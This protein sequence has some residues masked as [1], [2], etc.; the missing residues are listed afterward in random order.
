MRTTVRLDDNLLT[1]AK[2]LAVDT[3]RTLTQVI[4]DSLRMS[5]ATRQAIEKAEPIMLHTFQGGN[6][7]QPGVDLSNNAALQDLMDEHDGH[8]GR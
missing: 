5:L 7:L 2:K 3:G 4:E 8:F 1:E 6:G